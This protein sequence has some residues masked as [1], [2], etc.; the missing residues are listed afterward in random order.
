MGGGWAWM[1]RFTFLAIIIATH[2]WREYHSARLLD[3][4]APRPSICSTQ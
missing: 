2:A 3:S 1:I 4:G